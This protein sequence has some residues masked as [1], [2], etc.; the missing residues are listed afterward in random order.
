MSNYSLE[1]NAV[2]TLALASKLFQSIHSLEILFNRKAVI[3]NTTRLMF[4]TREQRANAY[5]DHLFYMNVFVHIHV[6]VCIYH[7]SGC[8]VPV[9]REYFNRKLDKIHNECFKFDQVTVTLSYVL[10]NHI[11]K[12]ASC[13]IKRIHVSGSYLSA[14]SNAIWIY[15]YIVVTTAWYVQEI[16]MFM[17]LIK[18]L[19]WKPFFQ[20][21]T[22]HVFLIKNK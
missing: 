19:H 13:V 9:H 3:C 16:C 12:L 10:W 21:S 8:P 5:T 7:Q 2:W 6:S 14:N 11:Y 17:I 4:Q 15:P 20:F 18:S 22:P 1:F